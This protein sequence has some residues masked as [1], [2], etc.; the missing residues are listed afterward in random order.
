MEK[1]KSDIVCLIWMIFVLIASLFLVDRIDSL[2]MQLILLSAVLPL[3]ICIML[4][5]YDNDISDGWGM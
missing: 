5:A 4:K 3:F 2:F 1:I